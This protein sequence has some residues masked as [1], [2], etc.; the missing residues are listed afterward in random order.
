MPVPSVKREAGV[1]SQAK[2]SFLC[3]GAVIETQGHLP[4]TSFFQPLAKAGRL[5]SLGTDPLSL[6]STPPLP[7]R[8]PRS[9]FALE[10]GT[11]G[12]ENVYCP[13]GRISLQGQHSARVAEPAKGPSGPSGKFAALLLRDRNRICVSIGCSHSF[14]GSSKTFIL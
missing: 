9:Q 12:E 6:P 3:F 10:G 11:V 7:F 8:S 2:T 5:R 13:L 1:V 4:F 14:P